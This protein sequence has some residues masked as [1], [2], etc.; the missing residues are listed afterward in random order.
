M[1]EISN[2][3]ESSRYSQQHL[4]ISAG[5]LF[6][7]SNSSFQVLNLPEV[8][9]IRRLKQQPYSKSTV[10]SPISVTP[11]KYVNLNILTMFEFKRLYCGVSGSNQ[12]EKAKGSTSRVH[13]DFSWIKNALRAQT[14]INFILRRREF[15]KSSVFL[16]IVC[17][18]GMECERVLKFRSAK[19]SV[20]GL[21]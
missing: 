17:R 16:D 5:C 21:L 18:T 6:Q 10:A 4:H 9:R 14:S 3:S 15:F 7:T 8:I 11:D 12:T 20:P 1:F 19:E 2:F 13:V